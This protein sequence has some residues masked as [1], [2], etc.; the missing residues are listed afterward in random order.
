MLLDPQTQ[1]CVDNGVPGILKFFNPSPYQFIGWLQVAQTN[2]LVSYRAEILSETYVEMF[3]F[4]PARNSSCHLATVEYKEGQDHNLKIWTKLPNAKA[5]EFIVETIIHR[6]HSKSVT[7]LFFSE[8]G[9]LVSCSL[10]GKWKLW[11][12]LKGTGTWNLTFVGTFK[13]LDTPCLTGS[14]SSDGSLLALAHPGSVTLWDLRSSDHEVKTEFHHQ[15]PVL[16]NY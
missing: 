9:R 7:G 2:A 12:K 11:S 4:S 10:D 14:C 5:C 16:Y 6:I 15:H 13:V 3:S 1:A 8:E